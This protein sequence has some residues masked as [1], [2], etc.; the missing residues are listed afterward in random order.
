M[1]VLLS[2]TFCQ[3]F[4]CLSILVIVAFLF[5]LGISIFSYFIFDHVQSRI[6]SF[7]GV[8]GTDTYQIDLSIQAFKNGGLLEKGPGQGI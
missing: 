5:I 1:T 2:A 8:Y 4:A 7:L 3:L 6:N